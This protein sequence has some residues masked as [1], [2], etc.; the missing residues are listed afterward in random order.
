M[1]WATV[2]KAARSAGTS[3]GSVLGAL[4]ATPLM[5]RRVLPHR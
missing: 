4:D 2:Q 1:K 5:G 3:S